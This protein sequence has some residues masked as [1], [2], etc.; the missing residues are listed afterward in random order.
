MVSLI[1][2]LRSTSYGLW[3]YT[4]TSYL[5]AVFSLSAQSSTAAAAVESSTL[6]CC[7]SLLSI[8]PGFGFF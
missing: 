5:L 3:P 4:S 2:P 8:M 6:C 7:V 1:L